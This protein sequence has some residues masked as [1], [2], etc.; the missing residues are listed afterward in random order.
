MAE[1][2]DEWLNQ[3]AD[4]EQELNWQAARR[5][6]WAQCHALCNAQ[7]LR[8]PGDVRQRAAPDKCGVFLV[9]LGAYAKALEAFKTHPP[10]P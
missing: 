8:G 6:N 9:R 1:R 2:V 5:R 3:C 4:A 10:T 7:D